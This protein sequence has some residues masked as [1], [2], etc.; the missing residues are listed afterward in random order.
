LKLAVKHRKRSV[1]PGKV[2]ALL[3]TFGQD[4][5]ARRAFEAMIRQTAEATD[6]AAARRW[7]ET[8]L[9]D[10]QSLCF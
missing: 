1:K 2:W 8:W 5:A 3:G 4:S 6:L 7:Y 10:T 9:W